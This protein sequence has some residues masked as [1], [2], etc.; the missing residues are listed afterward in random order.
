FLTGSFL[1]SRGC[2]AAA[3]F[4]DTA[5][6]Q[7]HPARARR[8]ERAE[9]RR[10]AGGGSSRKRRTSSA[11]CIIDRAEAPDGAIGRLPDLLPAVPKAG[12]ARLAV[13]ATMAET[14]GGCDG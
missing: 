1:H 2:V 10:R 12:Y 8:S 9:P 6:A 14:N 13:C 4:R 7:H 11:S 5:T 3:P